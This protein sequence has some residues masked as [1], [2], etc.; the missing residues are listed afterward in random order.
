MVSALRSNVKFLKFGGN[1]EDLYTPQVSP[2]FD[3][4]FKDHV[5]QKIKEYSVNTFEFK[6]DPLETPFDIDEVSY[7]VNALPN[8]KAGGTDSL[9]YEYLKYGGQGLLDFLVKTVLTSS[10]NP[11]VLQ[12][13]GQRGMLFQYSRMVRKIKWTGQ[14]IEVLPC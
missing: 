11:S 3:N 7:V 10:G 4:E 13:A 1:T 9:T 14:V 12:E 5:E 2:M 8:G 6:D